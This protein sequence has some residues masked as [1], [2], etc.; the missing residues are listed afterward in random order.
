[1]GLDALS[2]I[3]RAR[4]RWHA[5]TRLWSVTP[6]ERTPDVGLG[7]N[8]VST[9]NPFACEVCGSV[10]QAL[11]KP[12][13]STLTGNVVIGLDPECEACQALVR[14]AGAVFPPRFGTPPIDW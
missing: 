5:G 14:G 7:C 2:G 6:Y 3:G 12:S 9:E 13:A 4:A 1:M 8:D 11:P 10:G